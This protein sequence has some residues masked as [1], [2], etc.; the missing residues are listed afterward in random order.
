[1]VRKGSHYVKELISKKNQQSFYNFKKTCHKNK[2]YS[3][4]AGV[5]P[6]LLSRNPNIT[7]ILKMP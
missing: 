2:K 6:S 1:M 7:G 4:P 5:F 3:T